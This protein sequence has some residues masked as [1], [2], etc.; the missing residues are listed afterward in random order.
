MG[1]EPR[2]RARINPE[3]S[4]SVTKETACSHDEPPDRMN[5]W[6]RQERKKGLGQGYFQDPRYSSIFEILAEI[7]LFLDKRIEEIHT[8][9]A[10]HGD[11]KEAH[12]VLFLAHFVARICRKSSG[13]NDENLNKF[14]GKRIDF[15]LLRS[16]RK[17]V[18]GILEELFQFRVEGAGARK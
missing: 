13:K 18:E 11:I 12:W 4:K 6:E 7:S 2:D 10:V 5:E 15:S 1:T 17:A 3:L 14:N 16:W 8:I 9:L